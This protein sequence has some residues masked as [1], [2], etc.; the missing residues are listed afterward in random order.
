M[1][2]SREKELKN[3]VKNIR[4]HA[5]EKIRMAHGKGCLQDRDRPQCDNTERKCLKDELRP[6]GCFG[7]KKF[8]GK[9]L[10]FEHHSQMY[11]SAAPVTGSKKRNK[12]I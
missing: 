3:A 4:T 9:L 5:N 2:I 8:Y 6:R 10:A 12:T 11:P 7:T 1:R